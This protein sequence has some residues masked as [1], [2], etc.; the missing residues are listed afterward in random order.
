MRHI[1][2]QIFKKLKEHYN[3]RQI[4]QIMRRV[5]AMPTLDD[6]PAD[7]ILGYDENGLPR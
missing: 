1:L 7:E 6:R 3:R 5:D 4:E 2:S